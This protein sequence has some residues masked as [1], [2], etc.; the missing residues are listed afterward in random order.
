MYTIDSA[1]PARHTLQL[2]GSLSRKDA[3]I[4]AQ[5][6]TGYTHLN[7]YKARIKQA[8]SAVC[9]YNSGVESVRHVILQCL[10]SNTEK[11]RLREAAGY[12]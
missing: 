8:D 5:A 2:Y 7:E 4:L 3:G 11:Q 1:L 10:L 12:R 9:K 6:R